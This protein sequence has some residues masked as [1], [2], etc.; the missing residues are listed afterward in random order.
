MAFGEAIHCAGNVNADKNA[1]DIENDGAES[2]GGHELFTFGARDGIGAASIQDIEPMSRPKDADNGGQNRKENHDSNHVVDALADIGDGMS[3]GIA[4]QDH[5]SDPENSTADVE[6]EVPSIRHFRDASDG[7]AERSN[8]RNKA[9]EN[10]GPAPVFFVELMRA[11]KMAAAEEEGIFSAVERR[12]G[13]AADPITDLVTHDGAKHYREQQPLQGDDVGR[14][15]NP[16]G[17]QQGI[18]GEKKAD[19]KSGFDENDAANER[20]AAR[21]D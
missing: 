1:T 11:L 5:G 4:A 13:R 7:R 10:H 21:T 14:R 15:K 18:T 6:S 16:C 12:A 8:D 3:Q 9:R 19:K 17:D 20:S 2:A